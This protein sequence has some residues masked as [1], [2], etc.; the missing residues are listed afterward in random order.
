ME[1]RS[2]EF[3]NKFRGGHRFGTLDETG[4]ELVWAI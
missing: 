1:L 3:I 2:S 4:L